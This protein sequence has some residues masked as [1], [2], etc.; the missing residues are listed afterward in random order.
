[1]TDTSVKRPFLWETSLDF[2]VRVSCLTH[3]PFIT[4]E[5]YGIAGIK[6][7]T[8]TGSVMGLEGTGRDVFLSPLGNIWV[9]SIRASRFLANFPHACVETS[10]TNHFRHVFGKLDATEKKN[11]TIS[12][13]VENVVLNKRSK[14]LASKLLHT[15]IKNRTCL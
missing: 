6:A 5:A 11:H 15:F 3:C 2:W 1:M 12:W 14:I 9:L 13:N 7:S 10:T 4:P 8:S